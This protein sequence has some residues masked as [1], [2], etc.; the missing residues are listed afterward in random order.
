MITSSLLAGLCAAI[1]A[2][3]CTV[4]V[5]H[6]DYEDGLLGRLG[7]AVMAIASLARLSHLVEHEFS[8]NVSPIGVMLWLGLAIFLG[9]HLY[10]FLRWR[11]SG[12][13][14]WRGADKAAT[15]GKR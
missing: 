5:F 13:G 2:V 11:R 12:E 14:D 3:I 7:L 6:K 9:R 4:L 15:C 10:R 8:R 1:V